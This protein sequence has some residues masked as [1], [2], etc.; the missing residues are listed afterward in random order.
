MEKRIIQW[1]T[2]SFS[3]FFMHGIHLALPA[4]RMSQGKIIKVSSKVY[5]STFSTTIYWYVSL[6]LLY[7]FSKMECNNF[8]LE[9]KNLITPSCHQSPLNWEE[10]FCYLSHSECWLYNDSHSL[11]YIYLVIHLY[12]WNNG[13]CRP[14]P[15][16]HY[17]LIFMKPCLYAQFSQV[18][19]VC[20]RHQYSLLCLKVMIK[21]TGVN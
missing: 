2:L 18:L 21:L 20:H 13:T 17:I 1:D 11:H 16:C 5:A 10:Y 9:K 15:L 14:C 8:W 19:I 4:S 7:I 6:N 12:D 3:L